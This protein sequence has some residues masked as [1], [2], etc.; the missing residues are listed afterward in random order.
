M[1][2][3]VFD[4][5]I[6]AIS[7]EKV[8]LAPNNQTSLWMTFLLSKKILFT[9]SVRITDLSKKDA[10]I[11]SKENTSTYN[12]SQK[13]CS[14]VLIYLVYTRVGSG[15]AWPPAH[16]VLVQVVGRVWYKEW[17]G[18]VWGVTGFGTR[19][20]RAGTRYVRVWYKAIHSV[21]QSVTVFGTRCDRVG[22]K[23]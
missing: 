16:G 17:Q 18:M 2:K 21:V 9:F 3:E 23:V 6:I 8:V 1:G 10:R 14:L 13:L 5:G 15:F 7:S 11:R 20:T 12:F 22:Y 19:S 4:F